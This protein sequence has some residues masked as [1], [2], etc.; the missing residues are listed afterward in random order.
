MARYWGDWTSLAVT[1]VAS[2][3]TGGIAAGFATSNREPR[4]GWV[5]KLSRWRSR[6]HIHRPARGDL[7][8]SADL[9][10]GQV[11]PGWLSFNAATDTFSG[12]APT[13]GADSQHRGD[14]DGRQRLVSDRHVLGHC[15][16]HTAGASPTSIRSG[17]RA[18]RFPWYCPRTPS[19]IHSARLTYAATQ[20]NGQALPS[21]LTF[22]AATEH[23]PGPHRR[24]P[25]PRHYGDRDR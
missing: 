17:L 3:P 16:G 5:G 6:R 23:F 13:I 18:R 22:N 19:L 7:T 21:W 11:L 20:S 25:K 4:P 9:A 14:S 10:N 2:A 1:V 8:Y 12:T 15:S 24:P